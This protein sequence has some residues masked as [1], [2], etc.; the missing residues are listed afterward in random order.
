MT[1]SRF[2]SARNCDRWSASWTLF[3]SDIMKYL[4]ARLR[5]AGPGPYASFFQYSSVVPV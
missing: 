3:W 4:R 2:F 1:Q 5:V